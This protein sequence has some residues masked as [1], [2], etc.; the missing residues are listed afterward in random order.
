MCTYIS[1]ASAG[2]KSS[3]RNCG[4]GTNFGLHLWVNDNLVASTKI[5]DKTLETHISNALV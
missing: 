4:K 1:D 5:V 2:Q 3:K